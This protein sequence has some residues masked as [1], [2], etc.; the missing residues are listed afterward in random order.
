MNTFFKELAQGCPVTVK[1][2]PSQPLEAGS[3]LIFWLYTD[4]RKPV[5]FST[6]VSLGY[7]PVTFDSETGRYILTAK[8]TQTLDFCGDLYVGQV[9]Q[10][11]G[12]VDRSPNATEYTG[13]RIYQSP[14]AKGEIQ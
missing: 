1:V 14:I 6:D 5:K 11:A 3:V 2:T 12:D 9:V 10:L 13:L 4:K 8:S 7:N